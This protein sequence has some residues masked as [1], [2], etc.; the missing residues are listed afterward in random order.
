M[1]C[2]GTWCSGGLGSVRWTVGLDDLKR[3]FQPQRFCDSM[4]LGF[5][6]G[7]WAEGWRAG[8]HRGA[9]SP[10]CH[11]ATT[12]QRSSHNAPGQQKG[13]ILPCPA[14]SLPG[15]Q[16]EDIREEVLE[17]PVE[18]LGGRLEAGRGCWRFFTARPAPGGATFKAH[19]TD[20]NPASALRGQ[21][22]APQEMTRTTKP[23]GKTKGMPSGGAPEEHCRALCPHPLQSQGQ[24][25]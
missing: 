18:F 2:L 1:W 11:S 9:P 21:T 17:E 6:E 3:L 16:P 13:G 19:L 4:T 15:R 23:S 22:P 20:G 7:G 12:R 10:P 5:C 24:Q 25:P 14:A 8:L